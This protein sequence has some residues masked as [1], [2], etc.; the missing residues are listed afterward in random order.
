MLTLFYNSEFSKFY[1]TKT[2]CCQGCKN[3]ILPRHWGK[4]TFP[5][6]QDDANVNFTLTRFLR[7]LKNFDTIS[8]KY[9]YW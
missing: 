3:V 1:D 7:F 8:I 6:G 2:K 9:I 5:L 4:M